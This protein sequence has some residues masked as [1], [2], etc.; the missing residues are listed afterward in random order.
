[1]L[2]RAVSLA[3]LSLASGA[4][5]S[6]DD[7]LAMP[8]GFRYH[9][10]CVHHHGDDHFH[11]ERL[12]GGRTRVAGGETLGRCPF[13]RLPSV[14]GAAD[15]DRT[16][17]TT[18]PLHYYSDW[19]VYAQTAGPKFNYM[20]STWTVPPAP[21]SRGPLG[22][23]SVYLFNGLEDGDG[24][25]G[26]ASL[27]LQ[28]VLLFGKSGC[29]LNPAEWG[30]WNLQSYLVDG[31]GRAHCG[32]HI[33]VEPGQTVVGTMQQK[34]GTNSW[35]VESIAVGE[36]GAA[37]QTSSY[38]GDLA[39]KHIDSAYLTLEGMVIYNCATYPPSNEITF[40]NVLLGTSGA[41]VA[42]KNTWTSMVRHSEC[43]QQT[44]VESEDGRKVGLLWNSTSTTA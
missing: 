27:I 35:L 13:E 25:R 22:L 6:A 29:L 2:R 30:Q 5:A 1:M 24:V 39:D 20:T 33:K 26:K 11:V 28:P 44:Q 4:L 38:S 10:S 40:D 16:N 19:S 12:P 9:K 8:D 14:E 41:G 18:A 17:V 23:S 15:A 3:L 7:Y 32:S 42:G 43:G 34:P 37:N 31:N 21:K 36:K